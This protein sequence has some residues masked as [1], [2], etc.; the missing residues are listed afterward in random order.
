MT[1]ISAPIDW[2]ELVSKLRLPPRS[3]RRLQDLMDRN[4]DG[5]LSPGEREEL[6]SL[7][8]VSETCLS[9]AHAHSIFSGAP[10]SK[11]VRRHSAGGRTPRGRSLQVL[12]YALG[13]AR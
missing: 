13:A 6:E 3:D 8:E 10:R 5:R 12:R 2:V 11:S 4:N 7:V 9:P 1:V